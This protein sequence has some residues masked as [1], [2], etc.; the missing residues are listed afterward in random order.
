MVLVAARRRSRP[1][2]AVVLAGLALALLALGATSAR[3]ASHT[4]TV[5]TT[6]DGVFDPPE[7]EVRV[8]DEVT[9]AWGANEWHTVTFTTEGAPEGTSCRP[10]LANGFDCSEHTHTVTFDAAGEYPYVDE[11]TGAE[12]MVVVRRPPPPK[13]TPSPSPTT[14]SPS[15]GPSPSE[16]TSPPARPSPT[17]TPT[18]SSPSP[19]SS[20]TPSSPAPSSSSPTSDTPA[21]DSPTRDTVDPRTVES[22]STSP[23]PSPTSTADAPTVAEA[24]TTPS[25]VPEPTFE[26]FPEPADPTAPDDESDVAGEVA[27]GGSDGGDATRTVWGVVGGVTLLGTLGAF[28]RR[29]LFA[30]GWGS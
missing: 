8:D 3:A 10:R 26:D 27:V 7:L 23:S 24:D 13:P 17:P 20:P 12:G 25:P 9:F 1:L 21:D 16:T 15:P 11:I 28:G 6:E 14:S 30:D 5:A 19:S 18:P 4:V 29:V 2:G 22:E